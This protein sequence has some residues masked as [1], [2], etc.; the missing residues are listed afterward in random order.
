MNT[1]EHR[2]GCGFLTLTDAPPPSD[3]CSIVHENLIPEAAAFIWVDLCSS[4]DK[5]INHG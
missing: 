4:V 2:W 1:D 5:V 3:G